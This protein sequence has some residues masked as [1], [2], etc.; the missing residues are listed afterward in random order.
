MV[1]LAIYLDRLIKDPNVLLFWRSKMIQKGEV[2][3]YFKSMI[4]KGGGGIGGRELVLA[5]FFREVDRRM[6]CVLSIEGLVWEKK[7]YLVR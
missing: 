4:W 7:L 6:D 1:K 2:S 3:C 5:F